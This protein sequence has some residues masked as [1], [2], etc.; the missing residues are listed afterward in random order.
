[1]A[2]YF[3]KHKVNFVIVPSSA[4]VGSALLPFGSG[5]KRNV[6]DKN[7]PAVIK[8]R[9]KPFYKI[10][11]LSI[12]KVVQCVSRYDKIVPVLKQLAA[13]TL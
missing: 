11:F 5:I 9:Q 1:M 4:A 10:N 13:K 6:A 7:F 12:V 3:V 8:Q 2:L